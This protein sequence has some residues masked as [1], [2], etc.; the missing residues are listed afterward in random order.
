MSSKKKKAEL[1]TFSAAVQVDKELNR[2]N[3]YEIEEDTIE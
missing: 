2:K 1:D 3:T